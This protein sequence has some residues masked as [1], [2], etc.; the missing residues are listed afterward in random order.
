MNERVVMVELEILSERP[1]KE[2]KIGIKEA[3]E[4][5]GIAVRQ[6]QANNIKK[7]SEND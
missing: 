2:L 1:I 7:I 3:L 4:K 6:I 5:R